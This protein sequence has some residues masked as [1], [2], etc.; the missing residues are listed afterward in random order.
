MMKEH[1][2]RDAT[3]YEG[4]LTAQPPRLGD[5]QATDSCIMDILAMFKQQQGDYVAKTVIDK[6]QSSHG[7]KIQYFPVSRK[8]NPLC[9]I[10]NREPGV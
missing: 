4:V 3:S 7:L 2:L 6:V 1:L 10:P 9:M 8:P 5:Q